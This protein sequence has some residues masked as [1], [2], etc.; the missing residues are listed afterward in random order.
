MTPARTALPQRVAPVLDDPG[1]AADDRA[2]HLQLE[3]VWKGRPGLL[4]WLTEVDH[5]AIGKRYVVT[6]FVFLCL[7]RRA[8]RRS[9]RRRL[10]AIP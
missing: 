4:G 8:A 5:K 7:H 6:A 1:T 2:L 10:T 3:A 9:M